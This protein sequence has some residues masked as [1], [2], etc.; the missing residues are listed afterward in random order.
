M[1]VNYAVP[2]VEKR[3]H[4][5][6]NT[7]IDKA[8]ERKLVRKLDAHIIPVVMLLYLLSFLDRLVHIAIAALG[9][10]TISVSTS[11]MRNCTVWKKI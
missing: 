6:D 2:A 9:S 7:G 8:E 3:G 10:N 1:A 4:E 11:A 5:R